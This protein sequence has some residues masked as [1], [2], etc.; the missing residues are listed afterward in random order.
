[1]DQKKKKKPSRRALIIGVCVVVVIAVVVGAFFV[2]KSRANSSDNKTVYQYET[3]EK[4]S[5]T[6]T[7][8]ATG[9]VAVR[10]EVEVNSSVSGT[11]KKVN[12]K[13]GDT[14]SKGDVLFTLSDTDVESEIKKAQSSVISA[15]Q[16]VAQAQSTLTSAR[17]SYTAAKKG[18]STS[19][20]SGASGG[21]TTSV[22]AAKQ[23]VSAAKLGV[24]AAQ[25]QLSSARSDYNDAV[26]ARSD[27]KVK[28][29]CDGIVWSVNAEKGDEAS[30]A[31]ASSQSSSSASSSGSTPSSNGSSAQS[32]SSTSS[33][34]SALAIIAKKGQLGVQV[35]VNESDINVLKEGQSVSISL[36]AVENKTFKGTVDEIADEGS[37]SSG[38]VSYAVWVLLN[39]PSEAVKSGMTASVD[40]TTSKEDDVLLVS[41]AAVKGSGSNTY[42]LTKD[43]DASE[44]TQVKVSTGTR[45]SSQTVITS[46]L[47]EGQKIVTQAITIDSSG[48]TQSVLGS[49]MGGGQKGQGRRSG[50][51]PSGAPSGAGAP[52]SG[53][54]FP[55]GN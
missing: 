48:S 26:D 2:V 35:S 10:H 16:Q 40:I 38:V 33:S 42:V 15:Q 34:S 36:D 19:G 6:N 18:T 22:S 28:A 8:S 17:A 51:M 53:G 9:N 21:S 31:S 41:N 27:L 54:G 37:I 32:S 11:V 12:I 24:S 13:A 44:P 47:T 14:V 30:V 46:G 29:P 1:M 50:D 4:G 3:V 45:G 5:L 7:I 43:E 52:P 23:S 49:M 20:Q 25:A 55:G 39:D